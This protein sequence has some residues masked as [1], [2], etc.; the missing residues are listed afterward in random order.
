MILPRRITC[1]GKTLSSTYRRRGSADFLK[2]A[3][4]ITNTMIAGVI[5][6]LLRL[7]GCFMDEAHAGERHYQRGASRH[8]HYSSGAKRS[9]SARR[10]FMRTNPCPSTG[11]RSG[12]CPGY[13]VDHIVP[14]K[15]GGAHA[16]SNMQWQT[17]EEGKAKDKME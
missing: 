11:R 5:A 17:I 15:R 12:S 4:T 9:V 16:P 8:S 6:G 10:Q 3:A 13:V 7:T 1:F 14:L 2:V